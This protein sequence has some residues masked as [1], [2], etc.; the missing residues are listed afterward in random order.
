MAKIKMIGG[1]I[2]SNT[3]Y[4]DFNAFQWGVPVGMMALG[5]SPWLS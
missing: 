2:N 1:P 5:N 4:W 3:K